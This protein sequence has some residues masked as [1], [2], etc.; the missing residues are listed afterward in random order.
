[1][2]DYLLAKAQEDER[3]TQKEIQHLLS[4]DPYSSAACRTIGVASEL[5]RSLQDNEAEIHG[6]L[7]LDQAA[8][9]EEGK[10]CSKAAGDS[11]LSIEEAVAMA[12]RFEDDGCHVIQLAIASDFSYSKLAPYLPKLRAALKPHTPLVINGGA[13]CA[14][15]A[16]ALKQAGVNGVYHALCLRSAEEAENSAEQRCASVDKFLAA[17]LQMATCVES[18]GPEH[19][20]REI[21]EL[22]CYAASIK[23]AYSGA[24]RRIPVLDTPMGV[25]GTIPEVRQA[26]IVAITRLAMPHATVATATH[27]P[28]ALAAL[29][30]AS[31]FW[32]E[33]GTSPRA[34]VTGTEERRSLS[35]EELIHMFWESGWSVR[36]GKSRIWA[37]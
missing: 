35:V 7:V 24:A 34:S 21:A 17:G 10:T 25:M 11:V 15:H 23:S 33:T 6:L 4:Y 2:I 19:N 8:C 9:L 28:C 30:G 29:G 18:I 16:D 27:A 12:K 13:D 36:Q 3:L 5:S 20:N 32:A 22:I 1:M 37:V 31:F 14:A 26:Q